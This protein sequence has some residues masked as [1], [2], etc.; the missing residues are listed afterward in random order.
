MQL[1]LDPYQQLV[2][3]VVGHLLQRLHTELDIGRQQLLVEIDIGMQQ[4]QAVVV[5]VAHVVH[6]LVWEDHRLML[7]SVVEVRLDG[8]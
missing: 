7:A 4:L 2:V 3:V 8:R 6:R 1:G 5:H